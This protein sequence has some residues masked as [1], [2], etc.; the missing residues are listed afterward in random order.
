VSAPKTNE[1]NT[2]SGFKALTDEQ[3]TQISEGKK[4]IWWQHYLDNKAFYLALFNTGPDQVDAFEKQLHAQLDEYKVKDL[5]TRIQKNRARVERYLIP[6][7][8]DLLKSLNE[9][10][11]LP[12]SEVVFFYPFN[13]KTFLLGNEPIFAVN[14]AFTSLGGETDLKLLAYHEGFHGVQMR[15]IGPEESKKLFNTGTGIAWREGLAVLATS[16]LLPKLEPRQ[17]VALK[18]DD[19][20]RCKENL[21]PYSG[22]LADQLSSYDR[23]NRNFFSTRPLLP[24][25]IPRCGYYLAWQALERL[26]DEE[27]DIQKLLGLTSAEYGSL[28]TE[29][30]TEQGTVEQKA[31]HNKRHRRHHR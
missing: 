11:P 31:A 30:I 9:T 7:L 3:L 5:K 16:R 10:K 12:V 27:K 19:F 26:E 28:I 18:E 14:I 23:T 29:T 13:G 25:Y 1:A 21:I 20:K 8:T 15:K 22:D 17:L 4:E 24:Q 6:A 2:P